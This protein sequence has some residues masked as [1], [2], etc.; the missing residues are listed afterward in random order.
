[1]EVR[2]MQDFDTFPAPL[3]H[4]Q[5]I[6]FWFGKPIV[7]VERCRRRKRTERQEVVAEH[8]R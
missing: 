5:W 2:E 6:R 4:R 3:A 8:L 1:M 7:E